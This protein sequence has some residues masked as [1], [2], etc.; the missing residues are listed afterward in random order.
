MS[1]EE[2][3][4]DAIDTLIRTRPGFWDRTSCGV[5]RSLGQIP[6]LLDRNA[7]SV[8]TSRTRILL[9]G[10]L[11]GYKADVDMAL[12]A[13]S[14]SPVAETPCPCASPLAPC[15]APTLMACD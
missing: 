9:L 14:F 2:T 3:I 10:G 5:T 8:E 11:T 1:T 15:P 13:L 7:Y 12:H 6:A 4:K